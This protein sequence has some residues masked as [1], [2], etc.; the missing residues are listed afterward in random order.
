MNDHLEIVRVV[1]MKL[2][3]EVGMISPMHSGGL[4]IVSIAVRARMRQFGLERSLPT[5]PI[6]G[7]MPALPAQSA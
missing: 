7:P 6:A 4:A 3:F 2:A 1:W 5:T